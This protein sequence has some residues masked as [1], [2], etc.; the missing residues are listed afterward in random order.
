MWKVGTNN[1]INLSFSA[2]EVVGPKDV[3]H[4]PENDKTVKIR[5]AKDNEVRI[6]N[7]QYLIEVNKTGNC[8]FVN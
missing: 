7:C 3:E 1:N 6:D 2:F 4:K 8:I 5:F